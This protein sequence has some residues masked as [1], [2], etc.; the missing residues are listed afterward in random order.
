MSHFD[1]LLN[2]FYL[3]GV[4]PS[5]SSEKIHAA[6]QQAAIEGTIPDEDLRNVKETLH[7]PNPRLQAELSSLLVF[8]L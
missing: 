6:Y 2:P 4:A 5:A 7:K 3:L 1:I 8:R